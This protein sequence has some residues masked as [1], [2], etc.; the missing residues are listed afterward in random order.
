MS[1]IRR[2]TVSPS[3]SSSTRNTP[4]VDGCCGP[5]FRIMVRSWPGSSTG[6]GVRWAIF[7]Q[8]A[9]TQQSGLAV[10][11]HRVIFA[12]GMAFPILWHQNAP[13]VRMARETNTEE[14][15]NFALKIVGAG[16]D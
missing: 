1:G 4:C 2:T 15:E 8:R 10:A 11:L 5:M 9:G 3:I 7:I 6:V 14:I 12:Q 16:P 13:Q